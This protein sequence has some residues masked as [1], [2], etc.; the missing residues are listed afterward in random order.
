VGTG[1]NS[2]HTGFQLIDLRLK[3]RMFSRV[4][5]GYCEAI[6]DFLD[7]FFDQL[8]RNIGLIEL[9]LCEMLA[10]VHFSNWISAKPTIIRARVFSP[11]VCG[12]VCFASVDILL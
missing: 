1:Y 9:G 3:F 7:L 4:G 12:A 5:E 11:S 8:D 6:L 2:R 10:G